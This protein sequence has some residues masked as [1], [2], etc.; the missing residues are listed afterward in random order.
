MNQEKT[1]ACCHCKNY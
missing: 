1:N